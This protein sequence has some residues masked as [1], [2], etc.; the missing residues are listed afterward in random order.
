MSLLKMDLKAVI[1][2]ILT[3]ISILLVAIWNDVLP[4]KPAKPVI[5]KKW[6]GPGKENPQDPDIRPF[7]ILFS[8][9]V[10]PLIFTCFKRIISM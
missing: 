6:F 7:K 5:E 4:P 10:S 3:L 1:L 2:A 9:E 8:N